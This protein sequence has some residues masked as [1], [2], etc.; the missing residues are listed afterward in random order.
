MNW[1]PP[2]P[3]WLFCPADRPERYDKAAARA[4]VVILDLEDAVGA[5][6]KAG[7]RESVIA[8]P[9][10]P[11][12]TIVRVN[13]HGTDDQ[14]ADLE[15]LKQTEYTTVML[16]KCESAEQIAALA[17]L[18]V[19]ALIESPLGA[20]TVFDS[21]AA[22][23]AIGA[24]WGAEDLV[25][26]MGGNS[27]RHANGEYRAVAQQVRSQTLLA[28]KARGLFALD[29]VYLDIPDLDG[30]R[31]EADDAVAIGFDGKVAIHPSHIPV[32]RQSY[33]PTAE[34]I[35]WATAVLDAVSHNRGVFTFRG[36]M[37]DAP[38]LAH[39]RRIVARSSLS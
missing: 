24:M 15:A 37:V 3:A 4:D 33:A 36:Q 28:A 14:A 7:A 38:V 34:E 20:M 22:D 31:T 12:R 17:P 13:A 39:A 8:T 19:V 9:L 2:G 32:I 16:P 18:N 35:D 29:S 23:N 21:L 5:A 10:D 30:V 1:V 27:S 25:A 6:D 26:A 11:A